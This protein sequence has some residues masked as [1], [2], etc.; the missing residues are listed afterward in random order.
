MNR[1][2][3]RLYRFMYGRYGYDDLNGTMFWASLLIELVGIF[4]QNTFCFLASVVLLTLVM[5]RGLSKNRVKRSAEN[6][7]FRSL[8]EVPRR[9]LKAL[10]MARKDKSHRYFI[11][12][13]C[14]QICRV[15]KGRGEVTVHC[16]KC[17]MDFT[18]RA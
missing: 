14:H 4:T 15:P 10:A 5:I 1:L 9:L 8:T 13:R 16:P 6:R 12:P 18:R 3:N 11:C 7:K 17:G 2:R